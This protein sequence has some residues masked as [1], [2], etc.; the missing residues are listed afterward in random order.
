MGEVYRAK[1][2]ESDYSSVGLC[3]V[4]AGSG[5][6]PVESHFGPRPADLGTS[7]VRILARAVSEVSGEC[8]GRFGLTTI[9][10]LSVSGTTAGGWEN[11]LPHFVPI[12]KT[13]EC[14]WLGD[15]ASVKRLRQPQPGV[16]GTHQPWRL[17][18]QF[19]CVHL[20]VSVC[21]FCQ[22][23]DTRDDTRPDS[24]EGCLPRDALCKRLLARVRQPES[25]SRELIRLFIDSTS[26]FPYQSDALCFDGGVVLPPSVRTYELQLLVPSSLTIR[27][28]D[29]V[30]QQAKK[31]VN[32]PSSR[33]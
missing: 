21:R 3:L 31:C 13:A 19:L 4:T 27:A 25:R 22:R 12:R 20:F 29:N 1:I 8:P 16:S 30:R 18:C 14:S 32:L 24:L 15:R 26:E 5:L 28:A 10:L 33:L 7:A 11:P 17:V 2:P 9:E 23:N 6:V